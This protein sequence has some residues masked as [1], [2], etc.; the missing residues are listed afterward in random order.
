[1]DKNFQKTTLPIDDI[2]TCWTRPN[3]AFLGELKAAGLPVVNVG[4][5]VRPRN[6]HAAVREGAAFGLT[7]DEE[8]L[9]NPNHVMDHLPL[10]VLGQLS[11]PEVIPA[12]CSIGT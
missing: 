8:M 3:T 2:V 6:L 10:D 1:M 4:D 11:R 12:Q 9:F 5:S 7:L